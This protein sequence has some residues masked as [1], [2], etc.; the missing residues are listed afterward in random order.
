M[1]FTSNHAKSLLPSLLCLLPCYVQGAEKSGPESATLKLP[2]I[3][4]EANAS[5]FEF[6]KEQW[7]FVDHAC[8]SSQRDNVKAGDRTSAAERTTILK[9]A[10]GDE[11][12]DAPQ[13]DPSYPWTMLYE[14]PEA[15]AQSWLQSPDL[16]EQYSIYEAVTHT[17]VPAVTVK[18]E[19]FLWLRELP[20]KPEQKDEVTLGD[21]PFPVMTQPE[22]REL[23]DININYVLHPKQFYYIFTRPIPKSG[24]R[25][26]LVV[27]RGAESTGNDDLQKSR[28]KWLMQQAGGDIKKVLNNGIING[29]EADP[30]VGF[31]LQDIFRWAYHQRV[32]LELG[33]REEEEP[34]YYG[35]DTDAIP[36][37]FEFLRNFVD[38]DKFART[39]RSLF[40]NIDNDIMTYEDAVVVL[41]LIQQ[42][43]KK[44]AQVNG[45]LAKA[46]RDVEAEDGD[47]D[48]EWPKRVADSFVQNVLSS[49]WVELGLDWIIKITAERNWYQRF[50]HEPDEYDHE[51]NW[52]RQ[53]QAKSWSILACK[54]GTA[55]VAQPP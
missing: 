38:L 3:H 17:D 19:W 39:A 7:T 11:E 23:F 22:V 4:A 49:Q 43:H 10:E 2:V 30:Y 18:K 41:N 54:G 26:R 12:P 9:R 37:R 40:R 16:K 8:L 47:D 53:R 32:N 46:V 42:L 34:Y 27:H 1:I 15:F 51:S 36:R 50:F 6:R 48:P 35:E 44:W 24:S 21:L 5:T 31:V 25:R 29:F 55:N 52:R 33:N 13:N 45:A 20:K 28:W 14:K